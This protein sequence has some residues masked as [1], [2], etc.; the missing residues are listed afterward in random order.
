MIEF[1]VEV[2]QSTVIACVLGTPFVVFFVTMV[3]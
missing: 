2:L 1:V 3:K